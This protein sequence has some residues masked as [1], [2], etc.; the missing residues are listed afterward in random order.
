MID[1]ETKLYAVD[2]DQGFMEQSNIVLLKMGKYMEKMLQNDHKE[3][4]GE[5]II[6]DE[7]KKDSKLEIEDDYFNYGKIGNMLLRSQIDCQGINSE[8][9][10]VFF[11]LKTRAACVLRY[12]IDN[13]VD[14]LDYKITSKRGLHS[15]FERE[16]YDLI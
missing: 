8:G 10:N 6:N 1:K 15:S 13:Y 7:P 11:E 12:D 4:K 2:S 5:F 16:Y 14:Y 3:F 9:K